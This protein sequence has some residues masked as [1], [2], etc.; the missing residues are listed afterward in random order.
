[1]GQSRNQKKK[2]FK[3]ETSENGNP[4]YQNVWDA[5]KVILRVYSKF[6]VINPYIKEKRKISN[7]LAL[8]L[9]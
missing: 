2:K 3:Y 6:I 9:K 1:M 7:M 5:A 8:L 4:T